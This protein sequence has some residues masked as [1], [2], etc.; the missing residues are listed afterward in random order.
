VRRAEGGGGI[1]G[2]GMFHGFRGPE[3][4]FWEKGANYLEDVEPRSLG[5]DGKKHGRGEF[6]QKVVKKRSVIGVGNGT[7]RGQCS[8]TSEGRKTPVGK[9]GEG[10]QEERKPKLLGQMKGS[11]SERR[12][13]ETAENMRK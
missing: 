4:E 8:T 13:E 12:G 7:D 11:I 3:G 5:E 6:G 1:N 2:S 10:F 9:R